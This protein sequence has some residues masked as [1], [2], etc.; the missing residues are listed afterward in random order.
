[1]R[2]IFDNAGQPTGEDYQ[3]GADLPDGYSCMPFFPGYKFEFGKS[4]YR[5]EEVG[6]GGCVRAKPGMYW[7]VALLDIASMHPRSIVEEELFGKEYTERFNELMQVRIAVKHKEFDKARTMMG[8]KLE[9]YL[10]DEKSAEALAYTLKIPIN[11]VYGMTSANYDNPF[12]D[13]RNKDNIVAKRGALFM[14]NLKDEVESRMYTVAHIKTDSIKIP[15]ASPEIIQFVMDYG[16]E[17]GYEFEHEATYERMCLVNDAV[18]VAKYDNF[19]IRTKGGKHANEWTATGTQFQV[20]YVFKKLFSGEEITFD[21]LCETKAVTSALYLDFNEA[22]PD[23]SLFETVKKVR[24]IPD[25]EQKVIKIQGAFNDQLIPDL[26]EMLSKQNLKSIKKPTSAEM[27]TAKDWEHLTDEE[28]NDKIAEGHNMRFIGKVGR[29][30]PVKDGCGGGLLLRETVN[31]KTGERGFAA[32]T[33]TK[34]YRWMESEMLKESNH[35]ESIDRGY[36]DNLLNAAVDNLAK[37]GDFE[38][39]RNDDVPSKSNGKPPLE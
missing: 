24:S 37:Y 29:F 36:Y 35:E 20:P 19:G 1:M 11:M 32:A 17:Y 13:I 26:V 22:L 27:N 23:T 18:Y 38:R 28:L 3:P 10:T 39:F 34:G 8:G 21:D 33:G 12:H 16:K 4:T 2:R 31:R 14:I 6:E 30:C 7:N 9:K 25:R 15:D 5:G